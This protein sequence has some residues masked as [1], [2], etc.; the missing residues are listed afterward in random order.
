MFSIWSSGSTPTPTPIPSPPPV[1][2]KAE[3]PKTRGN[4]TYSVN[5]APIDL[6]YKITSKNFQIHAQKKL[7]QSRTGP[8]SKTYDFVNSWY[9]DNFSALHVAAT[10][11]Q[12]LNNSEVDPKLVGDAIKEFNGTSKVV[13]DGLDALC[14][15]HPFIKVTVDAYKNVLTLVPEK[16][17]NRRVAWLKIQMRETIAVLFQL[18]HI[19]DPDEK[20]VDGFS[21]QDR[22]SGLVEQIA[23][24]IEE[25]GSV[26]EAYLKK[27]FIAKILHH[28]FWDERLSNYADVFNEN[29]RLLRL[30]FDNHSYMASTDAAK[31]NLPL[32]KEYYSALAIFTKLSTPKEDKTRKFITEKRGA[33]VCIE[34]DQLLAEL[35]RLSGEGFA[36]VTLEHTGDSSKDL[37]VARR[38]LLKELEEDLDMELSRN[39]IIFRRKLEML[40]G[41]FGTLFL[42]EDY[43]SHPLSTRSYDRVIDKDLRA[44]WKSLNW[45]GSVKARHFI[46]AVHDYLVDK[47]MADSFSSQRHLE[48]SGSRVVRRQD[49]RWTLSYINI[50]YAQTILE[51][52]DDDALGVVTVKGV[53]TLFLARPGGWTL[54]QWIAYWA[55]GW[56]LGIDNYR[57]KIYQLIQEMMIASKKIHPSNRRYVHEYLAHDTFNRIEQLLRSTK[58]ASHDI[59]GDINL[60]KLT[61]AFIDFEEQRLDERLQGVAYEIDAVS[62]VSLLTGT[63]KIEKHIYPILYLL[64]KRDLGILQL[65]RKNILDPDELWDRNLALWTLF[66]AFDER[67]KEL[68]DVFRNRRKRRT[69]EE[70]LQVHACGMMHLSFAAPERDPVHNTLRT[71]TNELDDDEYDDFDVASPLSVDFVDS[72]SDYGSDVDSPNPEKKL[73][74]DILKYR[75]RNELESTVYNFDCETFSENHDSSVDG[76]EGAW[77]GHLWNDDGEEV[78]SA[79]GL[80][81][82][83][84]DAPDKEGNIKGNAMT[85]SGD[86]TVTGTIDKENNVTLT[87]EYE[88]GFSTYCSGTYDPASDTITGSHEIDE[89][90]YSDGFVRPTSL[91]LTPKTASTE[92][93]HSARPSAKHK[94]EDIDPNVSAWYYSTEPDDDVSPSGEE[95]DVVDP[96]VVEVD[97]K[98]GGRKPTLKVRVSTD[99]KKYTYSAGD[100]EDG[101]DGQ[102]AT[103]VVEVVKTHIKMGSSSSQH[104]ATPSTLHKTTRTFVFTRSPAVAWRFRYSDAQYTDNPAR[105]RWKFACAAVLDGVQRRQFS[106]TWLAKRFQERKRFLELGI[107]KYLDRGGYSP[108][109][110]LLAFEIKELQLLKQNLYPTDAHFY[111][112]L[113]PFI[114]DTQYTSH[115]G[116]LC[117]SC[118]RQILQEHLLCIRCISDDLLNTTDLCQLCIDKTTIHDGHAHHPSHSLVKLRRPLLDADLAWIIPK[119]REVSDRVRE[120]FRT[121][122]EFIRELAINQKRIGGPVTS[123]RKFKASTTCGSCG[124]VAM[125]PCWVCLNCDPDTFIC[126]DCESRNL[127]SSPDSPCPSHKSSHIL[128]SIHDT[129]PETVAASD[130]SHDSHDSEQYMVLKK[131]IAC[132]ESRLNDE[133]DERFKELES[134]LMSLEK[135]FDKRIEDMEGV[136]KQNLTSTAGGQVKE[137]SSSKRVGPRMGPRQPSLK[138]RSGTTS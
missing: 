103:E 132:L 87:L 38:K 26:C 41:D 120:L 83:Y 115:L 6:A 46:I 53:N 88:D 70:Q 27:G 125:V 78:V 40:D 117:S 128:L 100:E 59:R 50:A 82:L 80:V 98:D 18:R 37:A 58:P 131:R 96:E 30:V 89:V 36:G 29:R 61:E 106:W 71:W 19:R 60:M 73:S 136:L 66:S 135:S 99:L 101:E 62:T 8:A 138:P 104:V 74:V 10:T 5:I 13:F 91:Q 15:L 122:G 121:K 97:D 68:S 130:V 137:E 127:S 64:L 22:L 86:I 79:Q 34:D 2:E 44:V 20:L 55:A 49:D 124:I 47:F 76:L 113:I 23:M 110:P 94:H 112:S 92:T 42:E 25:M 134:R 57:R 118:N 16:K 116:R 28:Q 21:I 4:D 45:K 77:A 109:D 67:I 85:Y 84:L 32:T 11:M 33:R 1:Y 114:I 105:A 119:A 65:A 90:Y 12:P 75:N 107:R 108:R 39:L 31:P 24:D 133:S 7:E 43:V 3:K 81:Q 69:I 129:S 93:L 51:A 123:S 56:H 48:P 9:N 63:G 126:S 14:L 35:I 52:I 102:T 72:P 95:E 17:D 111:H 54:S